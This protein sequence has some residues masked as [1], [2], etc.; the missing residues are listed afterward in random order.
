MNTPSAL[1]VA[2]TCLALAYTFQHIERIP[3]LC[4]FAPG[5]SHIHPATGRHRSILSQVNLN[6]N[7]V[8]RLHTCLWSPGILC[9][10]L[11]MKHTSC[12]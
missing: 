8:G 9:A 11:R 7:I 10:L 1:H 5:H 3:W 4:S 12:A 6:K 2:C